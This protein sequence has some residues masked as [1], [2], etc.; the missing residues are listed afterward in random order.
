MDVDPVVTAH[1]AEARRAWPGLAITPETYAAFLRAK[2]RTEG[3][4]PVDLVLA[5]ACATG[6]PAAIAIARAELEPPLRQALV[7]T[8]AG[9]AVVDEAI[10]RVWIML[11]VGEGAQIGQYSGRGR[12]RSWVRSIG[13]RTIRRMLGTEQ[14]G[15]DRGLSQL[16]VLVRDPELEVMRA[17]YAPEVKQAL[18]QSMR[19]LT[20][21]QRNVLRQYHMDGLTID[22]LAALYHINRA[23]AAR[24]VAG[25]RL[26]LVTSTRAHIASTLELE[27]DEVD[28]VIRLVRSMISLSVRELA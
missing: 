3:P 14:A 25:A 10:Q 27:A 9:P 21:R 28:S 15:D 26:A 11:F 4:L 12:L 13:V 22:Q 7:R 23:T 2:P 8:G 17:I 1:L 18:A 6:D 5:A 20:P 19:E 24:W 16:P